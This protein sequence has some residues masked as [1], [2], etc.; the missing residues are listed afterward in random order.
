MKNNISIIASIGKN[1]ELGLN[2]KLVFYSK[3]D[4]KY[5]K[6]TTI[7]HNIVLGRKTLE[8]IPKLLNKRTHLVLTT[9]I[10]NNPNIIT[11]NNINTLLKYIDTIDEEVFVIGGASIYKQFIDYAYKLYLTEVNQEYEANAY[12]PNFNK[13]DY[14][15]QLIFENNDKP[16]YKRY[17]YT[18]KEM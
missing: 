7:N 15:K 9:S 10:I 8:S 18:R 3:E 14:Y 1:N 13:D 11:F 12:F 16:K 2:N 5:F 4:M 17:I 6:N